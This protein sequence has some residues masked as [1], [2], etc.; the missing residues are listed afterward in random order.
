MSERKIR[1]ILYI[2][3][4][5]LLCLVLLAAC[6]GDEP[7]PQ[8]TPAEVEVTPS[9]APTP[10]PAPTPAPTPEATP[11]T[12]AY[13]GPE[14]SVQ[15][16][17]EDE[18]FSDALFVGN[19][20]V[21]GLWGFG[22]IGSAD[23]AAATSASVVNLD[24]VRNEALWGVAE[25]DA[26]SVEESLSLGSYGKVY[27]LL[28]INEIGF[29]PEDF[30]KLYSLVLDTVAE[31]QPEADIYI[32][33]LTPVTEE[34]DAEGYPFTMERV[35]AYNE[36]LKALAEEREMYFVDLVEALADESGFLP[37]ADSTDGI[38]LVREKYPKWADYLRCH[39]AE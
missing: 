10:T 21:H 15:S 9:P 30:I 8:P 34:K 11:E 39:Y 4:P 17:V 32:M 2:L 14:L 25:E 24:R 36:A 22:G 12:D 28:G 7:A 33:G 16:A 27:L 20:L 37:E 1:K 31:A 13:F 29:E 19:S 18:F 23:Y 35:L 5:A 26:P 6:G 38:H 3:I